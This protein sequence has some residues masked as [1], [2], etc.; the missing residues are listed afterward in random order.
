LREWRAKAKEQ[1]QLEQRVSQQN[2]TIKTLGNDIKTFKLQ[3][4]ELHRLL[5]QDQETFQKYKHK[6]TQELMMAKRDNLKKDVQIRKL[7]NDNKRK[8]W[9]VLRKDDELKRIRK[10]NETLKRLTKPIKTARSYDSHSP[11]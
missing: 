3:K 4:I 1:K 6:R 7:T 8:N 10:V 11:P 9:C 5:K 2:Q